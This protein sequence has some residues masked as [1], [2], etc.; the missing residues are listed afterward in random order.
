M[1]YEDF[2]FAIKKYNS[3]FSKLDRGEDPKRI[4]EIIK[5]K[6]NII[7]TEADAICLW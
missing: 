4:I 2:Q 3:R 5:N 7:L 1:L 6:F